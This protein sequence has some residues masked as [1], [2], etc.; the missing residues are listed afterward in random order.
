MQGSDNSDLDSELLI[1]VFCIVPLSW[2]L[3]DHSCLRQETLNEMILK[4]IHIWG[5]VFC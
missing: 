3:R 2:P 1:L 5:N 4:E